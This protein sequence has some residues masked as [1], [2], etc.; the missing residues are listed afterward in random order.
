MTLGKYIYLKI[1]SYQLCITSSIAGKDSSARK[2][3]IILSPDF[4]A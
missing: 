3:I 1:F 4:V 2:F